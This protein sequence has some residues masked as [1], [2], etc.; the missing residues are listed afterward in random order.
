MRIGA[1]TQVRVI[2]G[3]SNYLTV[4]ELSA[5]FGTRGATSI[6]E[7]IVEWSSGAVTQLSDVPADQTLTIS[8]P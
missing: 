6:D 3:G 1:T 8:S 2:T 7:L 5:A 4:S